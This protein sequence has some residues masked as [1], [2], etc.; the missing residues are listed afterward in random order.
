MPDTTFIQAAGLI[1]EAEKVSNYPVR[2]TWDDTLQVG[3]VLHLSE[4]QWSKQLRISV[5]P[6][7]IS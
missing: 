5:K 1:R 4:S 2:V 3:A 6:K 7:L